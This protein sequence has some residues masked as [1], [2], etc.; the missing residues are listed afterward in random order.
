MSHR[1]VWFAAALLAASLWA[2]ACGDGATDPPPPELSRPTT[3]AVSPDTV[4]LTALDATVR[5]AVEVRDQYGQVMSSATVTWASSS[6]PVATVDGSGL[7]TAVGN[8]MTTVT[9]TSGEASGSAAVTV[10]Q[11]VTTVAVSPGTDTLV[12]GDTLRLRAA[13]ADANG[14]PVTVA[15]FAWESSD[16]AVAAVDE[17]GLV[18]GVGAGDVSVTATS[19]GVV[20]RAELVVVAP[21]PATIAIMPDTVVLAALGDTVRLTAEVKDQLGRVLQG[22]E[23]RWVSGDRV[24]AT[25]DSVGLATATGNG[26]TTITAA[27]GA[28]SGT[29]TVTVMQ[30]T[31]SI[32]VSPS[33]DTIGPGDTLQ[34]VAEAHDRN[35]HRVIDVQFTWTSSNASVVTV[36]ASGL[37]R[38]VNEGTATIAAMTRDT[39]GTSGITVANPDRAALVALYEATD[40]PNWVNSEN[41]LTDAPLREWYGVRT[42]G[43]GRVRRLDLRG[44]GGT[45]GQ[46]H[47]LSGPIPRELGKL[48]S[49]IGLNLSYNNISGAIPP[50]LGNLTNLTSLSLTNNR[51]SGPIPPE[52]GNL[53]QLTGLY[54]DGN[55]LSG[56][57]PPEL[58][59]LTRMSQLWLH[60]NRLSGPIPPE[61]GNL[62]RMRNLVLVYNNLTGPIPPELGNLAN[63]TWLSLGYNDLDGP[64]PPQLGNLANIESLSLERNN[65]SGQ[66]PAEIGNLTSLTTLSLGYNKLRGSIPRSFLEL[67][68]LVWFTFDLSGLCTPGITDFVKW[69]LA[70]ESSEGPACNEADVAVLTSLHATAGGTGWTNSDGWLANSAV[71]EWHGVNADSLGRVTK[72]DL[73]GNGLVGHLPLGLGDLA[74]MTVLRIGGNALSGRLPTS[75]TRVPLREL[76][77]AGT[78]L[79]VPAEASFQQWLNTIESH[80]SAGVDCPRLT[81]RDIL[82]ALYNATDG[83]NWNNNE[84]W[85]TDAPLNDWYGVR[86]TEGKVTGLHLWQNNLSGPIPPELG[87]LQSLGRLLLF[88][89]NLSGPIPPELGNLSNLLWLGLYANNLSGA[90]PSELGNLGNLEWLALI[91]NLLSGPIP[92]ELGNLGS[93]EELY[94]RSN[95]LSGAIP[96]E[97]G[98]LV[99]L[100]A[101]DLQIN[102]LTGP[103]PP[104]LG[105]LDHLE[106]FSLSHNQLSGPIPPELGNLQNLRWLGLGGNGLTG[107]IPPELGKLHNVEHLSLNSNSLTGAIPPELGD[108]ASLQDAWLQRNGLSGVI[109]PE[110]GSLG[111]L[112]RL[113][114]DDNRL[115]TLPP[116]GFSPGSSLRILDLSGN[117]LTPP[118][119][120]QFHGLENLEVLILKRIELVDLAP[121][122]FSNLKGLRWLDLRD[123]RFVDLPAGAFLGINGLSGLRL[124]GNPGAPFSLTLQP[125]RTDIS[126]PLASGPAAVVVTLKEGAP[127]PI[128]LPFSVH[129]GDASANAVVLEGGSDQS[130]VVTV[131]QSG[132]GQSGVQVV[133]GPAPSLPDNFGGIELRVADPFVLFGTVANRAPVAERASPL[134][135]LRVGGLS[136]SFD[137][138]S[139]FRDP[140]GDELEYS[141]VSENPDVVSASASGDRITV[142]PVA[143]G[144][145]SVGVI[146]TDPGGLSAR[147][148]FQ[149]SVR[150]VSPGLFDIDLILIDDI[151]ESIQTA[152][153]DAI[154]Y[155]ASI[156]AGTELPNV[157]LEGDFE[158]GCF[159]ITAPNTLSTVD[160]LVIVASVRE[161]DGRG[162]IL[163]SAGWCGIRAGEAGLPFM[164]AMQFDVADLQRLQEHGD[165]EEVI[166]HEIGH[167]LGFGTLWSHQGLLVNPSLASES[168]ADTHFK[169]PLAIEAFNSAGGASYTAGGKVPVENRAGPGSADAH[170]RESVLEHELMTPYQNVGVPDPLSAITIQ[171]L[172]DLGYV[173]DVDLAEPYRLPGAAAVAA[174]YEGN[175]IDY[176]DDIM[177]GRII[178]VDGDGRVIRV[179]PELAPPANYN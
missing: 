87:N 177:R 121:G 32:V 50:E 22:E 149:A 114:L 147:S 74:R 77:Y 63:L 37:V 175:R 14:H 26:T 48:T 135:R 83:P 103:I 70:I 126:D 2:N 58:G 19:F 68:N 151:S 166:L 11:I 6:G 43:T 25:V 28:A 72:L 165:I 123:N 111:R 82:E 13:A 138:S 134:R 104:E 23:V 3:V 100:R 162:G 4:Q 73:A 156:L 66:V 157:P 90:I 119:A 122:V 155:W 7:V 140:D 118:R 45:S 99:N 168:G 129:G 10:E 80:E 52:L 91:N 167:V 124:E 41:W 164:G 57:I 15:D 128:V 163:A 172:A 125:Q 53:D 40:G 18:A 174:D 16:T 116:T 54:L 9:A 8:G 31:T 42:D 120:A 105:N 139:Y 108:L 176:G 142:R 76:H 56:P 49:L 85:L 61:L 86:V 144:S 75:L 161:I 89:N 154:D 170:W 131:T 24:V 81:E 143:V 39:R 95:N 178:V 67:T 150:E 59:N 27:A 102:Q 137:V 55:N 17:T 179:I 78:N 107:A 62:T 160:D 130:A 110:L 33:A 92:P 30:S 84:N 171:S 94:L 115:T 109:P 146:A 38:G 5:L 159:S 106:D 46:P 12:A 93:L 69:R 169:G 113:R 136:S 51:L 117:P 21:A 141:V 64:I 71:G 36:N 173:V 34:L 145:A 101:L 35:G 44:T 112:E 20:G 96:P 158:L 153:D 60:R 98:N 1:R 132:G 47:G 148:S 152:F 88:A 97:L 79:C 133:V 127:L 65:L 29:A